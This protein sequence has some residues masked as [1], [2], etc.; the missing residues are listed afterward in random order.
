MGLFLFN[1]VEGDTLTEPEKTGVEILL[2]QPEIVAWLELSEQEIVTLLQLH[3][4]ENG[5]GEAPRAA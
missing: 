4:S 5:N 3:E 2:S 1:D